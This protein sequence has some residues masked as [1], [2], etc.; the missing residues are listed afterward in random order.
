MAVPHA[1]AASGGPG[2][3]TVGAAE[4]AIGPGA[5]TVGAADLGLDVTGLAA[6]QGSVAPPGAVGPSP[7]LAPSPGP[8]G[9]YAGP[10]YGTYGMPEPGSP[11][12]FPDVHRTAHQSE[13]P[14]LPGDLAG[15]P[16]PRTA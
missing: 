2:P 15:R 10:I 16:G 9:A 13:F 12:A 7:G 5:L 3:L 11:A 4:L 8:A 6:A 14:V 1:G